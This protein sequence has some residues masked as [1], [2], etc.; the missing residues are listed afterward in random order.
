MLSIIG[1]QHL[2]EPSET[3]GSGNEVIA[4]AARRNRVGN[5]LLELLE[6]RPSGES[7]FEA[8]GSAQIQVP[9]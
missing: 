1:Q 9:R 6:G 5:G 4:P 8:H 2:R 3:C 7:C